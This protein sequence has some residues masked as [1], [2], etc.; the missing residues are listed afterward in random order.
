MLAK[1]IQ[2]VQPKAHS[3]HS[4]GHSLSLSVKDPVKNS[5]LPLNTVDIAKEVVTLIFFSKTG[6]SIGRHKRKTFMNNLQRQVSKA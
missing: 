5:K 3:T 4:H 6:T 1:R 2:D